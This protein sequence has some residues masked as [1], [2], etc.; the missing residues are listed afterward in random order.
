MYIATN[1]GMYWLHVSHPSP[2]SIM[3]IACGYQVY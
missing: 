1:Y 2:L 3:H